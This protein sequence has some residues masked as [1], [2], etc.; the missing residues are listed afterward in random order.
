[1]TI[2]QQTLTITTTGRGTY[3]ITAQIDTLIRESTIKT[4]LCHV[5][6]HH[7]SASLIITEN[8]DP[9]VRRDLETILKRL[10]PD[11]DP[12]YRHSDEGDDDMSAHIR[13]MLTQTELTI[14]ITRGQSALGT[15]QGLYLYEHRTGRFQRKLTVTLYGE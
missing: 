7:T 6:I 14:P 9:D 11:G 3:N 5:F 1:M 10:A 13:C 15:W 12:A 4:G 2:H 8:A